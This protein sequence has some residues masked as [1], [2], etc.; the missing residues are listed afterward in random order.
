MRHQIEEL[1]QSE[2]AAIKGFDQ[3][4]NRLNDQMERQQLA[5]MRED[6]V[7]ALN[8][9]KQFADGELLGLDM[10]DNPWRDLGDSFSGDASFFADEEAL[11]T[12]RASVLHG[13]HEYQD[14]LR[15]GG[16][17]SD[18][19]EVIVNEILPAQEQHVR[20]VESYLL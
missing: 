1:I 15:S 6:H 20:I 4:L 16:I 11:E 17:D 10:E 7:K 8:L 13:C 14:A 18:L 2:V 5:L 9:L 3:L 19:R 12:F